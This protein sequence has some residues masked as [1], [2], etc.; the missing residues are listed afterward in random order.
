MHLSKKLKYEEKKDDLDSVEGFQVGRFSYKDQ[1]ISVHIYIY[2]C[3]SRL[4]IWLTGAVWHYHVILCIYIHIYSRISNMYIYELQYVFVHW[5]NWLTIHWQVLCDETVYEATY[6]YT[7]NLNKIVV[8]YVYVY[9]LLWFDVSLLLCDRSCVMR[10]YTYEPRYT[11]C[12]YIMDTYIYMCVYIV[13]CV[14][15]DTIY[16]IICQVLCDETG[17]L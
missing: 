8:Y 14:W 9:I 2:T 6:Y 3:L 7:M 1:Y 13:Y 17:S 11:M 10:R 12:T 15:N 5:G 16:S 4:T